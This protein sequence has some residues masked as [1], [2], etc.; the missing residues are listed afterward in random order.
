MLTELCR[1]QLNDRN[2]AFAFYD[3]DTATVD[4]NV[5][6]LSEALELVDGGWQLDAKSVRALGHEAIGPTGNT[7]A[8]RVF[9]ALGL[10]RDV[11]YRMLGAADVQTVRELLEG[12]WFV[13]QY[14]DCGWLQDHSPELVGDRRYRGAHAVALF[15]WWRGPLGQSVHVANP[16]FD[17]RKRGQWS[18][19]D[20][21][22]PAKFS[23]LR[24]AAYAYTGTNGV[25]SG[26]AI[27]PDRAP[28]GV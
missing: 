20:G 17:G 24:D 18:A 19:P 26:Y 2:N 28:I 3:P 13:V 25:T 22:Q 5:A 10:E 21:V 14:V 16:L 15:D 8:R 1:S 27:R 9:A 7:L 23:D 12:G 6:M 11:T 4:C